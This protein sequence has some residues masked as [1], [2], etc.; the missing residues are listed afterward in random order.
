MLTKVIFICVTLAT[1]RA[2][3]ST[4]VSYERAPFLASKFLGLPPTF[5]PKN[6]IAGHATISQSSVIDHG[7]PAGLTGN[8]ASTG[9]STIKYAD[10][11]LSSGILGTH[12]AGK[13]V[14]S[15][16]STIGVSTVID[17]IAPASIGAKATHV[18][19][20]SP[21]Y[22]NIGIPTTGLLPGQISEKR[23][24]AAPSS[25]VIDHVTPI[26]IPATS[27]DAS[28]LGY[29]DSGILSTRLTDSSIEKSILSAPA[30]VSHD[31][32]MKHIASLGPAAASFLG[33]PSFDY[34]RSDIFST[35]LFGTLM[36]KTSIAAPSS[37]SSGSIND[38]V[39]PENIAASNP[40]KISSVSYVTP[41]A[42]KAL[43][44][45]PAA[46]NSRSSVIKHIA[47]PI[48]HAHNQYT[49]EGR[50]I[51]SNGFLGTPV[52]SIL[53][54]N[55]KNVFSNGLFSTSDS[56]NKVL[57]PKGILSESFMYNNEKIK[58]GPTGAV[59]VGS[60]I[61][62]PTKYSTVIDHVAPTSI[63][64]SP[65]AVNGINGNRF[66]SDSL[67]TEFLLLL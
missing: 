26:V 13:T 52:T 43:I 54:A 60:E 3:K 37:I 18:A 42:G 47:T 32:T 29:S 45:D 48:D 14:I 41:I 27:I 10:I 63:P 25:S 51:L 4:E 49:H 33:L 57:F 5:E 24:I 12:I 34:A 39:A 64:T 2:G 16:P 9:I 40:T 46:I 11:D 7:V 17:H 31:S 59:I 20:S 53:G 28:S 22:T 61:A 65:V 55:E 15:E 38:H 62:T 21:S 36:G 58:D 30:A 50:G 1:V 56:A 6:V 8:A 66:Y 19:V 35:G 23:D 44:S 67:D